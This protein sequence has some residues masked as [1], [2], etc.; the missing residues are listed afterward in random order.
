MEIFMSARLFS[1]DILFYQRLLS[2]AGLYQGPRNGKWSA[3]VDAADQAFAAQFDA[4]AAA[5]ASFDP[6]SE[7]N[8][9]TLLPDTQRAAREFL[10]RAKAGFANYSVRIISGTRTYAE[11]D[12]IYK[13]GRF[14]NPGKPVTNAKGGQ[15][16]H[17]FGI[18]WDVGIFNGGKY[19]TGDSASEAKI[20][21]QLAA[22]VLT[23]GLAWGGNWAKFKDLPHYE[24]KLNLTLEQIRARF[25]AGK[26]Y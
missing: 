3:A 2:V 21:K 1:D 19:L 23:P 12:Q 20:Y 11:Q 26:P 25:E 16:N 13:K 18:A 24:R 22:E 5:D 6:R 9:R 7:G 8:I 14:G 4:I 10:S 15:S 17:N